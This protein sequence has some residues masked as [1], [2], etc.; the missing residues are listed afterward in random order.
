MSRGLGD[1]Y[2]RQILSS[3]RPT[4][5]PDEVRHEWAAG[6]LRIVGL[7]TK[8]PLDVLTVERLV[9]RQMVEAKTVERLSRIEIAGAGQHS[10][11]LRVVAPSKREVD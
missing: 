10:R 1:V 4:E 5:L 8:T 9:A 2:K 6:P 3:A 7:F 11:L